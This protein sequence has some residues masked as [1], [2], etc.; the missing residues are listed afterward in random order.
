MNKFFKTREEAKAFQAEHGGEIYSCTPRSKTKTSYNKQMGIA[1]DA[2]RE[3]VKM[4][5][6]PWCVCWEEQIRYFECSY[7]NQ[8]VIEEAHTANDQSILE[9]S[10]TQENICIRTLREPTID[11]ANEF[12]KDDIGE[13]KVWFV[14]ELSRSDAYDFYD[15]TRPTRLFG[16]EGEVWSND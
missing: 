7:D 8:E 15:M 11:E 6:T 5:E 10:A 1:F 16:A 2:R 12:L 4:N 9:C 14:G 3:L 13:K